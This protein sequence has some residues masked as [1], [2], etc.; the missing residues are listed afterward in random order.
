M[1]DYWDLPRCSVA[2][3]LGKPVI[4][5]T[6]FNTLT[7]RMD[8]RKCGANHVG[9]VGSAF[10]LLSSACVKAVRSEKGGKLEFTRF[11]FRSAVYAHPFTRCQS[12]EE[13]RTIAN[14]ATQPSPIQAMSFTAVLR[15]RRRRRM[16]RREQPG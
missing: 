5:V 8:K 9:A 10:E 3:S 11:S 13:P 6:R 7:L 1:H 15:R 16:R 14:A 2:T 12:A 4:R